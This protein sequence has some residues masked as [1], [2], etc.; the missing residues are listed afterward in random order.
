[1]PARTATATEFSEGQRTTLCEAE[2]ANGCEERRALSRVLASRHF[3][4]A[5][6]LSAFLSYVCEASLADE[7]IRITEQN[8]GVRVFRRPSDYDPGLDNIVR[9]YARQLR[10][11]LDGYYADEGRGETCVI[12][13]PRGGYAAIF[14]H[15]PVESFSVV[16]PMPAAFK[17]ETEDGSEQQ[18]V[19]NSAIDAPRTFT[20]NR[21]AD[22]IALT[23]CVTALCGASGFAVWHFDHIP[24]KSPLYRLWSQIFQAD[25]DTVVVPADVGFVILQQLNNRT[26][27]LAEYESWS[28]VEPYDH[29]YMSF[30]KAQKYTSML[31]LDTVSRLQQL[32]EAVASR[33][34][35]RAPRSLSTEDLNNDNVILI[36]SN[37][38]DPWMEFFERSLNFHFVNQPQAGRFWIENTHPKAGEAAIYENKTRNMTHE[39]YGVIALLGNLS[40]SGHVLIIEGLDGP[41]TEAAVGLLL[42]RDPMRGIL[43]QAT[44]PDGSLGNFE[45]LLAATS[46]DNRATGTH[47]V[48]ERY[49]P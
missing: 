3:N 2:A 11:R 8:I 28:R 46:V 49:Y 6:L 39:T 18:V 34:L 33:F 38:S 16:S 24:A 23:F 26:Y 15:R 7:N 17:V 37:Y 32:P 5:P 22:L 36:G 21:K 31:D 9:N 44:R 20:R 40:K 47:I 10:R 25:R 1:M 43:Q 12:D 19:S 29:V 48:A 14:R 27:N 41:G 13:M 30:L 45:I 4:K 42:Q 35:I